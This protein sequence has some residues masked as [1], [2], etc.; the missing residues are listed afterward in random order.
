MDPETEEIIHIIETPSGCHAGNCIIGEGATEAAAWADAYG[1][2]PWTDYVKRSAKKAW[3]STIT[4]DDLETRRAE[5][6]EH[7]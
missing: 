4:R 6:N 1:P 7:H 5:A 2:K 3:A